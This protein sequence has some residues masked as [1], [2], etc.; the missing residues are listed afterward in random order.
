MLRKAALEHL[1]K[2]LNPSSQ[3]LMRTD[4][5]VPVKDGN[6]TDPTRITCTWY[7]KF[8]N[9]PIYPRNNKAQSKIPCNVI[10]PGSSWRKKEFKNDIKT[11]RR[12][13]FLPTQPQSNIPL[14]LCWR[15]YR[16]YSK[17]IKQWNFPLWK[18]QISSWRIRKI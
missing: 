1:T 2:H 3:V 16:W 11:N 8:S 17:P 7:I 9:N 15:Q 12:S 5:N 13:S 14:R 18:C 4:F 6:I 10:A